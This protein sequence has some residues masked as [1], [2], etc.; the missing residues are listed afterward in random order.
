GRE[1][2]KEIR[3]GKHCTEIPIFVV[4]SAQRIDLWRKL[5]TKAGATKVLDKAAPV[6]TIVAEI[7]DYLIPKAKKTPPAEKTDGSENE[8]RELEE[9]LAELRRNRDELARLLRD[10]PVVSSSSEPN[11]AIQETLD[12][13]KAATQRAETAY[14]AEVAR[15]RQFEEELKRILEA[16]DELN[17]KIAK[18]EE[19]AAESHRRS[20]EL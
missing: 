19:S 11:V 14:E 6:E 9:Q 1:L 17:R 5:S 4:T 20:K 13:A 7:V 18:D 8:V 16:R 12:E 15:S 10:Q 2:I 3:K